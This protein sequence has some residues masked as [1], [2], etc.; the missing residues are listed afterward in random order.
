MLLIFETRLPLG[1]VD[2]TADFAGLGTPTRGSH[3]NFTSSEQDQHFKLLG[4]FLVLR[5]FL[6]YGDL[7]LLSSDYLHRILPSTPTSTSK[8]SGLPLH[9][10]KTA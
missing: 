6:Q 7:A 1:D 5:F 9:F 3:D 10:R 8:A 4:L 2:A